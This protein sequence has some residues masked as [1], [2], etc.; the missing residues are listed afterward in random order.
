MKVLF[1]ILISVN[2]IFCQAD[3]GY[4]IIPQVMVGSAFSGLTSYHFN[5]QLIS[6]SSEYSDYSTVY[7]GFAF[8][9]SIESMDIL[10]IYNAR[11]S[12][13]LDGYYGESSTG[14][15]A[16][17]YS[18]DDS[19]RNIYRGNARFTVS[20]L[21]IIFWIKLRAE[22]KIS[23]YI[24]IGTGAERSGIKVKYDKTN[25]FDI[26]LSQWYW[27]WTI[28]TGITINYSDDILF[29]LFGDVI[30]KE[31]WFNEG[32]YPQNIN[33]DSRNSILFCGLKVGYRL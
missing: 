21:P 6:T 17:Q 13:S 23:P 25:R 15:V 1:A 16:I 32:T 30:I 12:L 7:P 31:H 29:T 8:G 9:A 33:L 20:S 24:K 4:C 18:L 27:A 14:D 2:T 28:G 3:S 26:N 19:L 22:G 11:L 10:S 5:G